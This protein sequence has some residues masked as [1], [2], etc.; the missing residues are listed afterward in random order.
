MTT[1]TELKSNEYKCAAC[2]NVYEK[3]WSDEEAQAE[4]EQDF[5]GFKTE[6][7]GIIC[8]DCHK[9]FWSDTD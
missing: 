7:C 5:P 8:D 1:A 9:K 3:G 6:D 4:L 2:G